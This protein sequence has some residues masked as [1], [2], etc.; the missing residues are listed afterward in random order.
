[1]Q[2]WYC[3]SKWHDMGWRFN[4]LQPTITISTT[5]KFIFAETFI[6]YPRCS[7]S[8][9]SVWLSNDSIFRVMYSSNKTQF[10][11]TS[12]WRWLSLQQTQ[13][14][15]PRISH[16]IECILTILY[17]L[18]ILSSLHCFCEEVPKY[19]HGLQRETADLI[20]LAEANQGWWSYRTLTHQN[21]LM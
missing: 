8:L 9:P 21:E 13:A 6:Q 19:H 14:Q 15:K 12:W 2:Q 4:M 5:P 20:L 3:S 10:A 17:R 7:H 11:P 18:K 16:D 1:M